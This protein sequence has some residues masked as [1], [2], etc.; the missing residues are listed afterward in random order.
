MHNKLAMETS[1]SEKRRILEQLG[2]YTGQIITPPLLQQI[3]NPLP[4][5]DGFGLVLQ[6]S[7][8]FMS[9][10]ENHGGVRAVATAYETPAGRP[11]VLIRVQAHN[12]LS[13]VLVDGTRP[14]FIQLLKSCLSKEEVPVLCLSEKDQAI[15]Q[16][17]LPFDRQSAE[18]LLFDVQCFKNDVPFESR[19]RDFVATTLWVQEYAMQAIHTPFTLAQ[20]W[21]SI[22]PP[23][24]QDKSG[25]GITVLH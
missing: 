5:K 11:A 25:D 19:M 13:G 10:A 7:S 16:F 21:L 8:K 22:I 20:S 17:D 4:L 1:R 15:Q 6:V 23:V 12:T 3:E 9:N 2:I 14:E 18:Q 24:E